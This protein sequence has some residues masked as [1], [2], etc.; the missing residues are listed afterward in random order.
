MKKGFTLLELIIVIIILGILASLAIPR[1]TRT[2]QRARAAEALQ[3]LSVLRGSMER[4]FLR[5]DTYVGAVL[6]DG[7]CACDAGYNLDVGCPMTTTPRNFDYTL[8][9]LA[10]G[11]FTITATPTGVCAS[12]DTITIIETGV[13]TGAGLFAGI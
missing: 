10:A 4:H 11:T 12:T 7:S 3:M 9:N 13:V 8:T 1:F 5:G 6:D 2:T